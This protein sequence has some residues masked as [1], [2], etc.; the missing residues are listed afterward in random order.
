MRSDFSSHMALLVRLL[1]YLNI[2]NNSADGFN[3][4]ELEY[5]DLVR[6]KEIMTNAVTRLMVLY[7]KF[8][9]RYRILAL[10]RYI[11]V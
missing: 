6:H 1:F 9:K 10:I 5:A 7:F 3:L 2:S 8:T 11:G 4:S